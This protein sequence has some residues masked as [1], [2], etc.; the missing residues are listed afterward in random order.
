MDTGLEVAPVKHSPHKE[1]LL[2]QILTGLRFQI[3]SLLDQNYKNERN[4]ITME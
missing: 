2:F 3:S 4:L 1:C